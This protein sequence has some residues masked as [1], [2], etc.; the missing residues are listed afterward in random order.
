M[1]LAEFK[2]Q[3]PDITAALHREGRQ[4][5]D[6]AASDPTDPENLAAVRA[7]AEQEWKT[8]LAI[9]QEFISLESYRAYRVA[10]AKGILRQV[11]ASTRGR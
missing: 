9:R 3:Y 1:N 5:A 4:L 10:V 6:Q 8:S 2:K 11:S 7:A